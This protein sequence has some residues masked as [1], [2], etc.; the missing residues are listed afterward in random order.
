MGFQIA[1]I[2]FRGIALDAAAAAL[3][4]AKTDETEDFPDFP[5]CGATLSTGWT[6]IF[7]N[8]VDWYLG[9]EAEIRRRTTDEEAVYAIVLE[10]PMAVSVAHKPQGVKDAWALETDDAARHKDTVFHS[11]EPPPRFF[12]LLRDAQ[13]RRK[14][15]PGVDHLFEVPNALAE[16]IV[17]FRYDGD[18]H[19]P[20]TWVALTPPT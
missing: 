13:D 8:D 4:L 17:G 19:D 11:G 16:E 12:D 9:R 3:G 2:G 1:W 14:S 6:V 15:D 7:F 18:P 10:G 20:V 5:I